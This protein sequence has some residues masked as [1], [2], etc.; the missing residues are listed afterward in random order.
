MGA[1]PWHYRSTTVAVSQHP[2]RSAR[3]LWVVERHKLRGLNHLRRNSSQGVDNEPL[4]QAKRRSGL[5]DY[6]RRDD[7]GPRTEDRGRWSV[8][9]RQWSVGTLKL[10][11][12]KAEGTNPRLR[13]TKPCLPHNPIQ[14]WTY[15]VLSGRGLRAGGIFS[16][17]PPRPNSPAVNS[18]WLMAIP[19]SMR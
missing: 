5:Q 12:Q 15:S 4:S 8:V 11:K 17:R 14:L 9:S 3:L 10:A 2:G 19:A 16:H 13:T 7:R 6:A 18:K 1:L